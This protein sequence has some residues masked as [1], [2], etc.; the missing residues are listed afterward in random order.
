MK[1]VR[2]EFHVKHCT[3]KRKN[4]PVIRTPFPFP[5]MHTCAALS[6]RRLA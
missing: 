1:R 3:R 5:S 4:R 6:A 2:I